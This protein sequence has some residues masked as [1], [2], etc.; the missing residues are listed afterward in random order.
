LIP[1][2]PTDSL[3]VLGL[4]RMLICAVTVPETGSTVGI[5]VAGNRVAVALGVKVG[6]KVAVMIPPVGD[7][8]SV[9]FET[10]ILHAVIK[11]MLSKTKTK[12]SG[13]LRLFIIFSARI[14][15]QLAI[16]DLLQK[17]V[18]FSYTIKEIL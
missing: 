16:F 7:A 18:H 12:I 11:A 13:I 14:L 4:C 8:E 10:S 3:A 5:A 1:S 15:I 9:T 6:Y 2:I 17:G